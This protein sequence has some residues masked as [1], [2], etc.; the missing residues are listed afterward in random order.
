MPRL[1]PLQQQTRLGVSSPVPIGGTE[2]A[3]AV[4]EQVQRFGAKVSDFG[5]EL[6]KLD[7]V[8]KADEERLTNAQFKA[9]G[10]VT[11]KNAVTYASQAYTDPDGNDQI[12]KAKE[13]YDAQMAPQIEKVSDPRLQAIAKVAA[14]DAWQARGDDLYTLGAATKSGNARVAD[15]SAWGTQVQ[16]I[17]QDPSSWKQVLAERADV[18][19]KNNFTYNP[20]QKAKEIIA[21][22]KEAAATAIESYMQEGNGK[23]PDFNLAR[24]VLSEAGPYL[25]G[26]QAEMAKRINDAEYTY[27]NRVVAESHRA[28]IDL[29]KTTKTMQ[30]LNLSNISTAILSTNNPA[31]REELLQTARSMQETKALPPKSISSLMSQAH[32][33]TNYIANPVNESAAKKYFLNQIGTGYYDG[34]SKDIL[35]NQFL[36]QSSKLELLN[37]VTATHARQLKSDGDPS[38]GRSLDAGTSLIDNYL[39]SRPSGVSGD[40]KNNDTYNVKINYLKDVDQGVEPLQAAQNALNSHYK[41][42]VLLNFIDPSIV[43]IHS[44]TTFDALQKSMPAIKIKFDQLKSSKDE[45]TRKKAE[46][47]SSALLERLNA[48][49]FLEGRNNNGR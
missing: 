13:F 32:S 12:S 3:R 48:L 9:L 10:N 28:E 41:K 31:K 22:G 24:Q 40:V 49:K 36:Q 5:D 6:L 26:N 27:K 33:N 34:V 19:Q 38:F 17:T 46:Q 39:S 35:D 18:L 15:Q 14:D 42:E 16:Q 20:A 2:G 29:S 43:P 23:N 11:G 25:V 1:E 44:Q 7:A 30:T 45:A 47:L 4:G 8:K 37:Q 21:N